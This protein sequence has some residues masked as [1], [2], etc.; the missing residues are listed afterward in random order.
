MLVQSHLGAIDLLPA[1]PSAWP[2]GHV[3]GLRARGGFEVDLA[4]AEDKLTQA[5]VRC[6]TG[7]GH[8]AVRYGDKTVSFDL[9]PGESRTFG[10]AL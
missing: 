1:L 6:V 10:A 3:R 4:W 2:T 9:K 5:T 7:S 8:G